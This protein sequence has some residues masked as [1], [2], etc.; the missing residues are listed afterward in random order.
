M[1][2]TNRLFGFSDRRVAVLRALAPKD[3]RPAMLQKIIAPVHVNNPRTRLVID[4]RALVAGIK[5]SSKPRL[6]SMVRSLS[7]TSIVPL[8]GVLTMPIF[9]KI[10]KA[11]VDPCQLRRS[12]TN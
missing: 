8:I 6:A 4:S 9:A 2:I 5:R 10:E 1:C 7:V 11:S 12:S 3:W